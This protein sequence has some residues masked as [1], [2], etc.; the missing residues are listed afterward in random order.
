MDV[1]I[2]PGRL[3]WEYSY[4]NPWYDVIDEF[5]DVADGRVR[6]RVDVVI[7]PAAKAGDIESKLKL[8]A[9]AKRK[10]ST[11]AIDNIS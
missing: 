3:V 6:V 10:Y 11:I 7:Q 5:A 4:S 9:K 2:N 1:T 8:L